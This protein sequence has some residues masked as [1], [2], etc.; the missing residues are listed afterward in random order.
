MANTLA[1]D[2]TH[3]ISPK[4]AHVGLVQLSIVST[5]T[6][7]TATGGF[8]AD[9]AVPLLA[10]GIKHADVL[11]IIGGTATGHRVDATRQATAAQ[12]KF[13]LWNGSTEIADGALTQ[14]L[15]L[16]VFFHQGSPS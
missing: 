5:E 7:A 1:I 11:A 6:Y 14:T 12:W 3:P 16:N 9:L 2:Q 4:H 10:L 13:R 15:T 8:T